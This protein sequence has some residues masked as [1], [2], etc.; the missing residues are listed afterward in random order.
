MPA[1]GVIGRGAAELGKQAAKSAAVEQMVKSAATQ[2]GKGMPKMSADRLGRRRASREQVKLAECLARQTGG[3][4]S[5]DTVIG[6]AFHTVVWKDGKPLTAFPP[7][8]NNGNLAERPEL[9]SFNDALLHDAPPAP[10]RKHR[11]RRR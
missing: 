3:K 2:A 7:V 11:G 6:G 8:D 5:Y 4:L 1:W 10:E 9:Q